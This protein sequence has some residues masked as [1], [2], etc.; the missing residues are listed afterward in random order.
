MVLRHLLLYT[1]WDIEIWL[2]NF[3]YSYRNHK[4]FKMKART[5]QT[6]EIKIDKI[7][8]IEFPNNLLTIGCNKFHPRG[9][10]IAMTHRRIKGSRCFEAGVIMKN[11]CDV[12]VAKITL[13]LKDVIWG[14][15]DP[16]NKIPIQMNR[17]IFIIDVY[18]YERY[19]L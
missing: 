7:A 11:T 8:F 19:R 4:F 6:R 16:K 1:S 13:H 5:C 17:E 14:P 18:R 2:S 15:Y 3:R 12:I 10:S 9:C